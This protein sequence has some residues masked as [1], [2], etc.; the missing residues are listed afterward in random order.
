MA[1][2]QLITE[3]LRPFMASVNKDP[4]PNVATQVTFLKLGLLADL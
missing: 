1:S 3:A 2:V 4:K